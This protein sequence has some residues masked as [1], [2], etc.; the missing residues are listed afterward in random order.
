MEEKKENIEKK[1]YNGFVPA[2]DSYDER[3][4]HL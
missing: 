1:R 3:E 2:V 4:Q